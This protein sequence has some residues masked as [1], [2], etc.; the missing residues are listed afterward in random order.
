MGLVRVAEL[1]IG[2]D[3]ERWRAAGF[4]VDDDV[5]A[6][7]DIRV[8]FDDAAPGLWSWTLVHPDREGRL[9]LD[10]LPTTVVSDDGPPAPVV[11]PN[12]ITALDHLVV[13]T[14]DIERTT[15]AF[16]DID[17]DPR[18]T[19]DTTAGDGPLRQRF[20]RMGTIIEVIGP[21]QPDPEGGPARFWGLAMVSPD[22]DRT[23][24]HLGERL[25]RAKQAVQPGRRIATLR[26]RDVGI[27]VPIAVMTPHVR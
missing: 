8:R 27:T 21:P 5:T 16:A 25:G 11:H 14:P 6:L 24:E 23:A 1:C 18:R 9:D 15:A 17:V 7:G 4:E 19:R 22:L 2:D 12:G 13:A 3:P 10:G 26:T 20:F